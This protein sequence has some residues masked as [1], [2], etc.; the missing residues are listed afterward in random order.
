MQRDGRLFTLVAMILLLVIYIITVPP[1]CQGR[2]ITVDQTDSGGYTTIQAALDAATSGD[3]IIIHRGTYYENLVINTSISLHGE[4]QYTTILFGRDSMRPLIMVN[5][6]EIT[7]SNFTM[8]GLCAGGIQDNANHTMLRNL[9]CLGQRIS[10]TLHNGRDNTIW[11][12]TLESSW[13]QVIN[14]DNNIVKGNTINNASSGVLIFGDNNTISNNLFYHCYNG[15]VIDIQYGSNTD[16]H[17]N[18]FLN[19]SYGVFCASENI[20]IQNNSFL[21]IWYGIYLSK[22]H[23]ILIENNIF[24]KT[25]YGIELVNLPLPIIMH[26]VFENNTQ[27]ILISIYHGNVSTV[28]VK[29]QNEFYQ[30]T[31]DIHIDNHSAV[32]STFPSAPNSTISVYI[33]ILGG[34]IA[35]VALILLIL[36]I[37]SSLKRKK[38]ILPIKTRPRG[39]TILTILSVIGVSL[40]GFELLNSLPSLSRINRSGDSMLL[41][42]PSILLLLM[43]IEL[44]IAYGFWHGF[45]WSWGV[46][47][48]GIASGVLFSIYSSLLIATFSDFMFI[49]AG[50]YG[51]IMQALNFGLALSSVCLIVYLTRFRVMDYFGISTL[52]VFSNQKHV[53]AVVGV[54][55]ITVL[56]IAAGS[57]LWPNRPYLGGITISHFDYVPKDPQ[58]GYVTFFAQIDHVTAN[59]SIVLVETT[60]VNGQPHEWGGHE[61]YDIQGNEYKSDLIFISSYSEGSQAGHSTISYKIYIYDKSSTSQPFFSYDSTRPLLTSKEIVFRT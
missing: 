38:G 52:K 25:M 17:K 49:G 3:T 60:F 47:M 45:R 27:G 20:T 56:I 14:S 7:I 16:I 26:N 10:I 34:A 46:A 21:G 54:V 55:G 29:S 33:T 35:V 36:S 18:V 61:M 39:V 51:V 32:R 5:A 58:G 9:T 13:I 22:P 37:S 44:A 19:G 12:T 40:I 4:N 8:Q 43:L 28:L 23:N 11:N 31:E 57:A 15:R 2:I 42:F 6:D 59:Q 50:L 24:S 1:C 48:I 41:V 30:N 53:N